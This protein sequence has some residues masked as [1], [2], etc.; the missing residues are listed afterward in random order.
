MSKHVG[1]KQRWTRSDAKTYLSASGKVLYDRGAWYAAFA[2]RVRTAP[3]HE[4]GLPGSEAI[5]R[6]LGPFKRPRNAM[7]ALEREITSL[8]NHHGE[9]ISFDEPVRTGV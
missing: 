8:A 6:R 1:R 7:V 9:N 5:G 2:Y 3:D 4:G